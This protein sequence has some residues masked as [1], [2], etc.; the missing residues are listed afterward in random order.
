MERSRESES[1]GRTELIRNSLQ[2]VA[3]RTL[4]HK[5]LL[6]AV[7][8]G[9]FL[10]VTILSGSVV[11]TNSLKDLAVQDALRPL[12]SSEVDL[13]ITADFGPLNE[14]SIDALQQTVATQI[15]PAVEGYGELLGFAGR[16]RIAIHDP[17][18]SLPSCRSPI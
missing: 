6:F 16:R 8:S 7:V 12:D 2:L 14:E 9:V 11:Y 15:D 4:A 3:R 1:E 13:L 17:S 18:V 10:A 5:R